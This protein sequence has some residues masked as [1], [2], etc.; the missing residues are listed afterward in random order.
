VRRDG[1]VPL[2]VG[3]T[4]LWTTARESFEIRFVYGRVAA[5]QYGLTRGSD[6]VEPLLFVGYL[7]QCSYL[8]VKVFVSEQ[9]TA[10]MKTN[11]AEDLKDNRDELGIKYWQFQGQVAMMSR[12]L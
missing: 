4:D 12:T 3:V 11:R 10:A 9:K 5:I 7:P 1:T 2:D 8:G 6:C